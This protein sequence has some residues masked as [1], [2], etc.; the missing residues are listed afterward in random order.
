V[1]DISLFVIVSDIDGSTLVPLPGVGGVQVVF[2]SRGGLNHRSQFRW[3]I[4]YIQEGMCMLG[5]AKCGLDCRK[6]SYVSILNRSI[7]RSIDQSNFALDKG[8]N[9]ACSACTIRSMVAV[10]R[11]PGMNKYILQIGRAHV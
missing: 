10:P 3:V 6:H 9:S 11:L 5:Y 2:L 4:Q 8:N 7:N 1:L